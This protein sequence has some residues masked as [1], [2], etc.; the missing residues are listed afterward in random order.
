VVEAIPV[1]LPGCIVSLQ[2]FFEDEKSDLVSLARREVNDLG[3]YANLAIVGWGK[4]VSDRLIRSVKEVVLVFVLFVVMCCS[5]LC[6]EK[7]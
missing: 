2:K 1:W 5:F 3:Q 7:A 4:N 6:R